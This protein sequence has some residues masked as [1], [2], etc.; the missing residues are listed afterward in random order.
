[1]REPNDSAGI[2]GGV[3]SDSNS[4][5]AIRSY[6]FVGLCLAELAVVALG[7]V[8]RRVEAPAMIDS[9]AMWTSSA[10]ASIS[11]RPSPA[12]NEIRELN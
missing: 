8:L 7:W 5:F 4:R 1:M 11:R 3:A 10:L 12:R 6:P 9:G 2:D